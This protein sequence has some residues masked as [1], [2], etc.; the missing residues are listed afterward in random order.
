LTRSH[1]ETLSLS[2]RTAKAQECGNVQAL[3]TIHTNSSQSLKTQGIE[4]FCHQPHL[5]NTTTYR[6]ESFFKSLIFNVYNDIDM[7]SFRLAQIV[8]DSVLQYAKKE[9]ATV[10]DRK[11]KHQVSQLLL[12]SIV[13]SILLELGFLSNPEESALLQKESYQLLLAHGV[14][15]GID[16]F[17]KLDYA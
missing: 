1:D 17:L 5:F 3:V 6:G 4:T 14:V 13:P 8:H 12:G 7:R 10:V 15:E 11:V 2:E 16:T 9:N